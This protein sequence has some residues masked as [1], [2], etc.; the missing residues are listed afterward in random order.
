[1]IVEKEEATV[2]KTKPLENRALCRQGC[3]CLKTRIIADFLLI[4]KTW[5][6][7]RKCREAHKKKREKGRKALGESKKGRGM[8]VES[9]DG[10]SFQ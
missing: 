3:V 2:E 9:A 1:M 4:G 6:A 10:A 8:G 7:R 5:N